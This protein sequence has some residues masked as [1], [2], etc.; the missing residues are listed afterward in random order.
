MSHFEFVILLLIYLSLVSASF[1]TPNGGLKEKDFDWLK[2][3]DK[4]YFLL[5]VVLISIAICVGLVG[6]VGLYFLWPKAPML[7]FSVVGVRILFDY[8]VFD[9]PSSKARLFSLENVMVSL[10]LCWRL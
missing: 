4:R 9:E 6:Y 3:L 7:F 1:F 10:R 2:G 8:F 5:V